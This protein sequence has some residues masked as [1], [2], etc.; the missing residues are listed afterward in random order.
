MRHFSLKTFLF[1]LNNELSS[2]SQD[3]S[4]ETK[5]A[6]ANQDVSN[7][8]NKFNSIIDGHAPLRPMSMQKNR[9]SDKSW[10]TRGILTSIKTRNKLFKKF[11]KNKNFDTDKSKIEHNKNYLNILIHLNNLAKRI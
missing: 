8:V 6:S 1:D 2:T 3:S 4:S 11:F 10:I 7:L 5:T 9:L